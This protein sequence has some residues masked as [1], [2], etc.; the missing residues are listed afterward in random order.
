MNDNDEPI[1]AALAEE[2]AT[3]VIA[4][5]REDAAHLRSDFELWCSHSSA[6]RLAY[7]RMASVLE[8]SAVLKAA[9][10]RVDAPSDRRNSRL[11]IGLATA[12][13]VAL[14]VA[15]TLQA[16]TAPDGSP[17]RHLAAA[18][19][20]LST[21]HGQIRTFRLADGSQVTLDADS[22]AAVRMTASLRGLRLDQGRAR[23]VIA[24]DARPFAIEASSGAVVAT[25]ASLDVGYRQNG[26]VEVRLIAGDASMR[27]VALRPAT[28]L[29]IDGEPMMIDRPIAFSS[30]SFTPRV[31]DTDSSATSDWPEGWAEYR[32]IPL[33]ALIEQ[34]NRYADRPII[35][36]DPAVATMQVSGRFRLTDTRRF[37]ARICALFSLRAERRSDGYHLR[38]Q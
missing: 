21:A 4:M 24:R 29:Q 12:A 36:D 33:G 15:V 14:A 17:D 9:P 34:A 25:Q 2:A 16:S 31:I 35:I 23:V 3:W 13:V 7:D 37:V 19:T 30:R 5:R 32:S 11:W 10:D 18:E 1:P 22:S 28:Y 8:T 26:E 6:H 20:P 38:R 27:G